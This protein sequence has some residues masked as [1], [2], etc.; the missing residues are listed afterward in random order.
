MISM[1]WVTPTC[2]SFLP[3]F[4]GWYTTTQYLDFKDQFPDECRQ[5]YV[6]IYAGV[7]KT[8]IRGIQDTSQIVDGKTNDIENNDKK[9]GSKPLNLRN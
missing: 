2:I 1:A 8:G 5:V 3:I 9:G 7:H 4:M 6:H